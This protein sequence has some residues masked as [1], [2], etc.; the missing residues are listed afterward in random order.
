MRGG[1]GVFVHRTAI[2]R[3]HAPTRHVRAVLDHAFTAYSAAYTTALH[4]LRETSPDRLR[5]LATVGHDRAGTPRL[6]ALKLSQ[7]LFQLPQPPALQAALASLP[8]HVHESFQR[9]V[10][11]TLLSYAVLAGQAEKERQDCAEADD[12]DVPHEEDQATPLARRPSHRSVLRPRP[13]RRPRPGD[14]ERRRQAALQRL[15][16]LA[17]DHAQEVALGA[18]LQ[19]TAEPGSVPIPFCRI[20]AERTCGLFY[21]PDTRRYY[22]RLFVS[23]P[24]SRLARPITQAG[25]YVDLRSGVVY[26]RHQ[27][28]RP[29][30][31]LR[32]F[33][34]GVTSLL[35]PLECGRWHERALRFST[36]ALLSQRRT[37]LLVGD[38]AP[39]SVAVPVSAWLVKRGDAYTLHVTFQVP[40]P[41]LQPTCT[42]LGVDRGI[43]CLAAGAVVSAD[44]HEVLDTLIL[45]GD[46]LRQAQQ[47][48]EQ[49][50]A[51]GQ[52][53]G[54]QVRGRQRTRRAAQEIARCANALVA[55]AAHHQAQII[56]E[57]LNNFVIA[58]QHAPARPRPYRAA[59]SR[60]Q[61]QRLLMAVNARL[62]LVGL[63]PVRLVP[64]A[65]TSITCSACG[66]VSAQSRRRKQRV[67]FECVACGHAAHADVQ[68]GVN[69][70][71]K[72]RWYE[73]RL[74]EHLAKRPYSHRTSWPK[75]ITAFLGDAPASADARVLATPVS[76][77]RPSERDADG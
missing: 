52:Q 48:V 4:V 74:R 27:D 72:W 57:E 76:P 26:L 53:R 6:S 59:H 11:R 51:T 43:A 35:V 47:Q 75:Y 18:D 40:V 5:A 39:T 38:P 68:A 46:T 2:L 45:E 19:C 56:M 37:P 22:A 70:A 34:K 31:G 8:G 54:R 64:P 16:T 63:P 17:D 62:P 3:L 32:S 50:V 42:L 69:I 1:A 41:P 24:S 13:P 25:R 61:Y 23:A 71:R 55:L 65:Y 12:S 30:H 44:T 49:A 10:A 66:H 14:G 58:A 9:H 73:L 33:G 36:V 67:Q 15:A 7:T 77:V 28:A 29:W 21:N 20:D 60:R